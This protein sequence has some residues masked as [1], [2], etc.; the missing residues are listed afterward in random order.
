MRFRSKFEEQVAKSFDKQG[1]TYLYEPSKI[2]YQLSC[3][4]TPDF[5]LP[6]GIY[7]ETKGFLKPSDRRKHIAIKDQ[8]PDLDIR[9]VFMRDNKLSKNSKHTYV[10]WA[11]K[12]GF[13]A[14]VWPNIPPDWFDD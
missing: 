4:Y 6:N 2:T 13:Q 3:S 12:H 11:E 9:F 1:H 7:L 14:C 8:H 5:C 10:S